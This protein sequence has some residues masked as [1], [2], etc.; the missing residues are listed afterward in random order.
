[1]S[2][3]NEFLNNNIEVILTPV[4]VIAYFFLAA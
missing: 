4:L 2:H 3:F 1:M